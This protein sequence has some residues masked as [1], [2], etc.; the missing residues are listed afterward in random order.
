VWIAQGRLHEAW[1][2]AQEQGLA[3]DDNL[4]YLREFEHITLA[5]LLLTH[6]RSSAE[7]QQITAAQE[8]L[9]RLLDA[10]EI[11]GRMGSAIELL[12]LQALAHGAQGD[13]PTALVPLERALR[14]AEPEGYVQLF[15][16]EGP[17]LAQL[18]SAA[19]QQ[20][21]RSAY[22]DTLL[23]AL[24]T[25]DPPRVDGAPPSSMPPAQP[26]VEPLTHRELEVLA[27]IA[28]G[29][30][31]REIAERLFLALDTVKGHN[32]RIF[33]KLAVKRRTEAVAKARVL[34]LLPPER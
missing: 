33:G 3:V 29:L 11:G 32:R 13:I 12:V 16:D 28:A 2:W 22:V 6:Y 1:N 4:R 34:D 9:A 23:A 10:A 30:T 14:L 31:N 24:G 27:L 17:P 5:R 18:L 7:A 20:G 8:L 25:V 21:L 26:L 15:V 19:A